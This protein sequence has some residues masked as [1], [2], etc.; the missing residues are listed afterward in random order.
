MTVPDEVISDTRCDRT[1]RS[2]FR[3][4]LWSYLTIIISDRRC[5]LTWRSYFRYAL[6]P[7]LTKLFQI[8]VVILPEEVISDTRCDRTWRSYFRYALWSYLK[9]LFQIRVVILPE[10]VI[11]DTHCDL[12]WLSYLRYALWSYLT[13]V[14]SDTRCVYQIRHL[15]FEYHNPRHCLN[16]I[17][18]LIDDDIIPF[19][20]IGSHSQTLS[21]FDHYLSLIV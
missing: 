8:R 10:E 18:L 2:Y 3:Y 13:K 11:S 17:Y 5:D 20:V 19:F 9:K 1:W 4:A 21:G 6:W 7:Y 16:I 14:L 15:R 12:T